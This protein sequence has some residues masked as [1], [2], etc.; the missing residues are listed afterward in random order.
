MKIALITADFNSEVTT[1][2]EQA[3]RARAEHH[4]V[5]ISH[6]IHVP[7]VYDMPVIVK[8]LL[9][10]N[11]VDAVVMI[12]AV[13]KGE[14][15]HDELICHAVAHAATAL[16]LQFDKPVTLGI[17]G[18]GMSDEQAVDRIDRAANAVDAAVRLLGILK[19]LG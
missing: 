17:T 16:S 8:R 15:Q 19:D 14:T 2:M 7:G 6:A 12:G 5:E 4:K 3:A 11:D 9:A 13:I 1:P 10:R 18:P